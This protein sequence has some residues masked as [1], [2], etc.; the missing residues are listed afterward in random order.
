MVIQTVGDLQKWGN[1]QAEIK[2]VEG[3]IIETVNEPIHETR[4]ASSITKK[5]AEEYDALHQ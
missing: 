4:S 5:E 1:G 2:Q 3:G